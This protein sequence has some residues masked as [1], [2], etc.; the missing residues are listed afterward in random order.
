MEDVGIFGKFGL[1]YVHFIY[2]I[3]IWYIVW[4]FGIFFLVLLYCT[5]TNLATLQEHAIAP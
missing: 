3:V 4:K 1:F 5:K 2:F